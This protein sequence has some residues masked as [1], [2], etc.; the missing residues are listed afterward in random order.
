MED[1]IS[2]IID[3]LQKLL[4]Y[5]TEFN[6]AVVVCGVLIQECDTVQGYI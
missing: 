4:F 1:K 5:T 6:L 2:E 3:T